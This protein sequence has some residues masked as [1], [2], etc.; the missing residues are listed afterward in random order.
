[1]VYQK[2][3]LLVYIQVLHTTENKGSCSPNS[4]PE[5]RIM[6]KKKNDLLTEYNKSCMAAG[7]TYAQMQQKESAQMMKHIRVPANYRKASEWQQI[8]KR[9]KRA[10]YIADDGRCKAEYKQSGVLKK[11][12]L[13]CKWVT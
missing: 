6:A 11:K 1:M 3:N 4:F 7:L 8:K 12:C 9:K 13:S 5:R 10:C 2:I